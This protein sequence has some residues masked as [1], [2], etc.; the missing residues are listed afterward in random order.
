MYSKSTYSI[1]THSHTDYY[2][3]PKTSQ[4]ISSYDP[5]FIC[6]SHLFAQLQTALLAHDFT[7]L[8]HQQHIPLRTLCQNR[9]R[10]FSWSAGSCHQV[11]LGWIYLLASFSII[12]AIWG[13]SWCLLCLYCF[14]LVSLSNSDFAVCSA[15]LSHLDF[16]KF[17]LSVSAIF[18]AWIGWCAFLFLFLVVLAVGHFQQYLCWAVCWI[19]SAAPF[20]SFAGHPGNSIFSYE[21]QV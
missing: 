7:S 16:A 6:L 8:V 11:L 13:R 3:F 21:L 4:S 14:Q 9:A 12:F 20:P 19:G 17:A 10:S 5:K 15:F 18:C 1:Y 2:A